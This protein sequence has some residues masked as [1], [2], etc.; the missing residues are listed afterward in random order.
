MRASRRA[1][2]REWYDSLL[3]RLD[4][5]RVLR[6]DDED[7]KSELL[8]ELAELGEPERDIA[9]ELL[10]ARPLAYPERFERAH[11]DVMRG[12]EVLERNGGR[13]AKMDVLGPF[14]GLASIVVSA[15]AGWITRR[16]RHTLIDEIR[17]L[18]EAREANAAPL[19]PEHRMLRRA[20]LQATF[21]ERGYGSAQIGIPGFLFTGAALSTSFAVLRNWLGSIFE[22]TLG[23]VLVTLVLASIVL[24]LSSCFFYGAAVARRRIRLATDGA[25]ASLWEAIGSCGDPPRDHSLGF[26]GLAV[27][28]LVVSWLAV[29]VAIWLIAG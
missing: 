7:T 17:G 18:Y 8:E 9:R 28:L 14:D 5:V 2:R 3:D 6:A 10:A 4:S 11:R 27:A 12:L 22:S 19:S 15:L 16:Y 13:R 25:A 21:L 1:E 20:R 26:A 29:P 24:A 23:T